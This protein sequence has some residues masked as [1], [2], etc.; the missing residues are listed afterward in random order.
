MEAVQL[1]VE[2]NCFVD[3][4]GWCTDHLDSHASA[5]DSLLDSPLT[6]R[7]LTFGPRPHVPRLGGVGMHPADVQIATVAH[8]K[9]LGALMNFG[10]KSRLAHLLNQFELAV[11]RM[12]RLFHAPND[13]VTKA[14]IIQCSVW[15][16]VFYGALCTA[17]ACIECNT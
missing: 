8:A 7:R 16:S 1:F 14:R 12:Q 6:G 11:E 9:E 4:W 10:R 2:P 15:L 3:N 13:V 5:M 17:G